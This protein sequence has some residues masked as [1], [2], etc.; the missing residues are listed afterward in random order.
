MIFTPQ[1]RTK[2]SSLGG[3]KHLQ[4]HGYLLLPPL[5]SL[6]A[7]NA[8]CCLLVLGKEKEMGARMPESLWKPSP[9]DLPPPARVSPVSPCA[10]A[11]LGTAQIGTRG[12]C[13][14]GAARLGS[15]QGHKGQV[16]KDPFEVIT[17]KYNLSTSLLCTGSSR[18]APC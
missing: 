17:R 11:R 9:L 15:A 4:C 14:T 10:A 12:R 1:L 7:P 5:L 6:C 18:R 8:T 3:H 16:F 13:Q 2:S